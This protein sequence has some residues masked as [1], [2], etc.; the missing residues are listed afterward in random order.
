MDFQVGHD[1]MYAKTY[2]A[3]I[4]PFSVGASILKVR[5]KILRG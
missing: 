4:D 2:N 1:E 5:W 3:F